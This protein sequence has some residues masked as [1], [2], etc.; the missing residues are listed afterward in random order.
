MKFKVALVAL[1]ILIFFMLLPIGE[2]C[3]QVEISKSSYF[4]KETF[5][6]EI[7]G[8]FAKKLTQ[9][10][11]F[12][13]KNKT[14]L[15]VPFS[16][17]Q[18]ASNKY[19]VY[20]DLPESYDAHSFA[21]KDVLC[22]ENETLISKNVAQSFMI[23][24]P[25]YFAYSWLSS[26]VG[27]WQNL[28]IEENAL[29]LLALKYKDTAAGKTALLEKRNKE[30]DCWPLTCDVKST[31]LASI[32]V[33]PDAT[34]KNWLLLSQN[35]VTLSS[36]DVITWNLMINSTKNTTCML[37]INNK[38]REISVVEGITS[39]DIEL[40][41][42][43]TIIITLNCTDIGAE[44]ISTYLGIVNKFPLKKE[45]NLLKITLSNEKCWG[46]S[47]RS[48]CNA[49]S[50]AYALWALKELDIEDSEAVNW[51]L[52][53]AKT[54]KEKAF[55]YFFTQDAAVESWLLNNQ[56]KEGYWKVKELALPDAPDIEATVIASFALGERGEHAAAIEKAKSWLLEQ[57]IDNKFGT[58]Q[59]TAFVLY[60]IFPYEKIEPIL[61]VSPAV[62]KSKANANF[63]IILKNKGI[64]S[65]DILATTEYD[66]RNLTLSSGS[67]S[68]V[69]FSI[70]STSQVTT[71]SSLEIS[72]NSV[73][74]EEKK[75][76]KIPLVIFPAAV[77]IEKEVN[78]TAIEDKTLIQP[79]LAFIEEKI[80]KTL[81]AGEKTVLEASIK[82][83]S[84]KLIEN[85]KISY[86]Y[87]LLPVLEKIEPYEIE[88]LLPGEEKKIYL[89]LN[90]EDSFGLYSG[91]IEAQSEGLSVS[92]QVTFDVKV[93]EIEV[94][95]KT[96]SELN[97][98]ICLKEEEC[99]GNITASSDTDS[100][101]LGVCKKKE[102]PPVSKKK[103][104]G[105]ALLV[106]AILAV[107][108]F[109]L[110]K[111]RKK[112]KKEGM[113]EILGKIEEKYRK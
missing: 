61:S 14:E 60:K 17:E 42:D 77:E 9:D 76:F 96:C 19:F 89:T 69:T 105:I 53:N 98:I 113:E 68:K 18:L 95:E 108:I 57:Y 34:A 103:L 31:A 94:E 67:T 83:P 25:I 106:L 26:Q 85:I 41:D 29:A 59:Q 47:F 24:K 8:S 46:S 93:E 102:K 87:G 49:E 50:T 11:L 82:N 111:L 27:N 88:K 33:S 45:D 54:T 38:E 75:L 112:P 39:F 36:G 109:L 86:S 55:T 21:V 4:P 110:L 56:A 80:E 48:S 62:I 63:S 90:A 64:L 28:S 40:P 79:N 5:Q 58:I 1:V 97:G 70:P 2:A 6:A 35:S 3:F 73:V 66:T 91:L 20:F 15:F 16:L 71:F 44:V 7:T 43:E 37:K 101:C 100:C 72:Y 78:K 74:S 12:L 22:I 65:V 81:E 92:L 107:A 84:A 52:K 32:A 51:L 13:Y 99:E 10:N 30:K 104:I 23:K